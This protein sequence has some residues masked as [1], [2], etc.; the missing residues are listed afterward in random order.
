MKQSHSLPL[1][2]ITSN[3]FEMFS[4]A[5]SFAK[6]NSTNYEPFRGSPLNQKREGR[7]RTHPA[8]QQP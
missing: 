1:L 6:T 4:I 7:E 8:K 2:F 3:M 5:F